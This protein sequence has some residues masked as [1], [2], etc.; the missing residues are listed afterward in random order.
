MIYIFDLLSVQIV[1]NP[2]L[3]VKKRLR[4]NKKGTGRREEIPFF[5]SFIDRKDKMAV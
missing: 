2:G 3:P 1:R 4:R 5:D